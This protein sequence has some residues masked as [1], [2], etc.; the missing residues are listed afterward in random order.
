MSD[1]G[2]NVLGESTSVKFGD[3]QYIQCPASGGLSDSFHY[4]VMKICDFV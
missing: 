4:W 3:I 2:I 1:F